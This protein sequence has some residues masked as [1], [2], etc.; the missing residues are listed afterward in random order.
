VVA[1]AF[2]VVVRVVVGGMFL[3]AL[4]GKL[5]DPAPFR[6]ALRSFRVVP[7]RLERPTAHAV[8]GAEA[9][10]VLLLPVR[11]SAPV[12][13]ALAA[14]LLTAFAVGTARVVARGD[15]VPCGCFGRS[16]APIGRAHTGRNALLAVASAAGAVAGL[17][18]APAPLD[19]PTLLVLSLLALALVAVLLL[20]D[21]LLSAPQP[22]RRPE[23][24][25]LRPPVGTPSTGTTRKR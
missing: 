21:Q 22:L 6:A 20:T 17:T 5:R 25:R 14:V 18:R 8:L 13:L 16:A 24:D 1:E 19:G 15:R 23:P 12:G 3:V 4:V 2:L 7:R 9:A 10:V 11:A